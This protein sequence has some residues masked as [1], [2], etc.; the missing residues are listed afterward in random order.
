MLSAKEK[1]LKYVK[2]ELNHYKH[3]KNPCISTGIINSTKF[4]DKMYKR[5]RSTNC[6]PPMYETLEKKPQELELPPPQ[7]KKNK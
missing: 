2:N 7:K 4:R 3:K 6:D 5:P 1:H